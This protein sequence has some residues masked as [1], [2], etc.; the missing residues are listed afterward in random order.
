MFNIDGDT[1]CVNLCTYKVLSRYGEH[2]YISCFYSH[3]HVVLCVYFTGSV[4]IYVIGGLTFLREID[5]FRLIHLFDTVKGFSIKISYLMIYTYLYL[6]YI[7]RR[8]CT[9]LENSFYSFLIYNIL[10]Y[11]Y[12][13]V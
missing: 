5:S 13:D 11:L 8:Y 1:F 3:V 2:L 4:V 7:D 9:Y 6:V 12:F 10:K